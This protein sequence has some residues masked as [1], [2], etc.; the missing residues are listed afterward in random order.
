MVFYVVG[1]PVVLAVQDLACPVLR[2][3][4]GETREAP[5]PTP[6]NLKKLV[7]NGEETLEGDVAADYED[8]VGPFVRQDACV[9]QETRPKVLDG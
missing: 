1:P 8:G 7:R 9:K 5:R 6:H 3:M 4:F 2:E